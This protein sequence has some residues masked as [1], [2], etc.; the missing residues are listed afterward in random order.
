MIS[1]TSLWL[2]ILLSAA[3]AWIAA[4]VVWMVLPH[5]RSD[6]RGFRNEDEVRDAVSSSDPAPGHYSM[7]HMESREDLE[8]PEFQ[9]KMEEGPVAFVRV[10]AGHPS[11]GKQLSLYFLYCLAVSVVVAY[12]AGRTLSPG[13]EYLQV[14]RITGTVAWVAY[15]W[16][17]PVDAIWFGRPWG[18][19][20]KHVFDA[21]LY[22]LL[23]AGVFGWLWP[24]T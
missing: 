11:M 10:L 18:E 4:S 17:F 16:A 15:G 5:H 7:P 23:T 2:P 1:L 8:D 20:V 22:G 19:T 12:V 3:L 24:G 6:F 21:F 13:T 9:R 14:F